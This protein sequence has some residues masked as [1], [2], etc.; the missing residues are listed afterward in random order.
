MT[1][2]F[3]IVGIVATAIALV[4]VIFDGVFEVFDVDLPGDGSVSLLALTGGLGAFGWAGLILA[5]LTDLPA[6][7]VVV[8]AIAVGFAI[9]AGGAWLTAVLR[10][11]STPDGAG[12]ITTMTGV[13]GVMDTAARPGHPGVVRVVYSGSPRTL[14]AHVTVDVAAGALVTVSAVVSPDVVRVTPAEA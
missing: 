7:A 14:T 5:S 12:S 6:W 10:R 4:A 11:H 13:A 1:T 9:A 3:L 8:L 2:G